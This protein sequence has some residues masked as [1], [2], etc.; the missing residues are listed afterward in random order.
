MTI[1]PPLK[2]QPMALHHAPILHQ[3]YLETPSYFA[4]LGSAV[5]SLLEV[6]RDLETALFDN[7]RRVELIYC[8]KNLI[9]SVDYKMDFPAQGDVTINL[10]MVRGSMQG[11]GWGR[12]CIEALEHH[13]PRAERLLV[14]VF[15]ERP[16]VVNFW[17]RQ[18]FSF[19]TDA[20]PVMT[21]YAKPLHHTTKAVS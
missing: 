3:L 15:G 13:L 4:V 16:R 2:F 1:T 6:S 20:R 9:G 19:A 10:L 11:K 17:E 18:G 21:W 12:R 14:G 8:G 5:P 7:R